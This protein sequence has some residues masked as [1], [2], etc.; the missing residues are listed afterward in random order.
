[1]DEVREGWLIATNNMSSLH[2]GSSAV[3]LGRA[4]ERNSLQ[5]LVGSGGLDT[6]VKR[7]SMRESLRGDPRLHRSIRKGCED[8]CILL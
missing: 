1:M 3:G 2:A 7:L 4:R 8:G 6:A 5:Q